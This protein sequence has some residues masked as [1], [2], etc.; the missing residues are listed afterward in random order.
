MIGPVDGNATT[1]FG[2]PGVPGP[3]DKALLDAGQVARQVGLLRSS[4]G[5]FDEAAA[6]A[7]LPKG[8]RGGGRDR[9]DIAEHVREAER[10]YARKVGVRVAP[11][12]PWSEQRDRIAG[13]LLQEGAAPATTAWPPRYFIRRTAWHVLDHAWE[14]EGK[15]HR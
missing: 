15:S 12:T 3:W 11:H 14:I 9:D 8:P 4:W 7:V 13:T 1:D 2:K 10:S 5:A 6:A